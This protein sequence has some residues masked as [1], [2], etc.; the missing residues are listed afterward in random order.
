MKR[1]ILGLLSVLCFVLLSVAAAGAAVS[2]TVSPT[3]ITAD[4]TNGVTFKSVV[5]AA[6]GGLLISIHRDFHNA[7]TLDSDETAWF[8]AYALD[9]GGTKSTFMGLFTPDSNTT[10]AN[11]VWTK[12]SLGADGYIS[13]GKYIVRVE[14]S[15]GETATAPFT[16]TQANVTP[17]SYVHV[18]PRDPYAGYP[19]VQGAMV[20]YGTGE[21]DTF[22]IKSF[23]YSDG[24]NWTYLPITG[25]APLKGR[26]GCF[27]EGWISDSYETSYLVNGGP[28]NFGYYYTYLYNTGVYIEGHVTSAKDGTPVPGAAMTGIR[29]D[30]F[31][32]DRYITDF[33]GYYSIPAFDSE[34]YSVMCSNA[35]GYYSGRVPADGYNRS[36]VV[37]PVLGTPGVADFVAGPM[38][39]RLN[40]T[41]RDES[42]TNLVEGAVAYAFRNTTSTDP[43]KT[44]QRAAGFYS[45]SA[46]TL[47]PG[48]GTGD[49]KVGVCL[50]CHFHPVRVGG[51]DKEMVSP[52]EILVEGLAGGETRNVTLDAYYADGAVE[53]RVLTTG[54]VKA[55]Y[56]TKVIAW[57]DNALNG[58]D[59]TSVGRIV[60]S[61]DTDFDGYFRLPLL[62]GTW[63]VQAVST[64][65]KVMTSHYTVTI[66]TNGD[67]LI[68]A[69]AGEVGSVGT[70]VLRL[71]TDT[72]GIIEV[73]PNEDYADAMPM[74]AGDSVTGTL[75]QTAD[76]RQ[77]TFSFTAQKGDQIDVSADFSHLGT[78]C[79]RAHGV[80]LIDSNHSTIVS[81]YTG[82][83]VESHKAVSH[84]AQYTGT[85][86]IQVYDGSCWWWNSFTDKY[87]AGLTVTPPVSSTPVSAV[88]NLTEGQVISPESQPSN[89]LIV[90]GTAADTVDIE[91]VQ[92][93]LDGGSTWNAATDTS[94]GGTWAT[95]SYPWV[96]NQMDGPHS[97]LTRITDRFGMETPGPGVNVFIGDPAYSHGGFEP[98]WGYCWWCDW[99]NYVANSD[100]CNDG[101]RWVTLVDDAPYT[102]VIELGASGTGTCLGQSTMYQDPNLNA[103]KYDRVMLRSDFR[104]VSSNTADACGP[105]G[106]YA[107]FNMQVVYTDKYGIQ[108]W[109]AWQF[110][111]GSG[112]C[113][114]PA[115]QSNGTIIPVTVT[116][117]DWHHFEA[118]V[119]SAVPD[120][121][122]INRVYAY[123]Q[124][125][126][127]VSHFDN[128]ALIGYNDGPKC[129]I[130]T[131]G[132]YEVIQP[133]IA[134]YNVSGT[135]VSH[136]GIVSVELSVNVGEWFPANID[137]VS[138]HTFNWSHVKVKPQDG[139]YTI[140]ARATDINGTV[141]PVALTK[142]AVATNGISHS[143]LE[144]WYGWCWYCD[145]NNDTSGAC[146]DRSVASVHDSQSA[147]NSVQL[148]STGAGTC[149]GQS[150]MWQDRNFEANVY[151]Q[152][153]LQ[154]NVKAMAA[155]APDGCGTDGRSAPF[156]IRLD[157]TDTA[158]YA[159]ALIW[160][161][162][163]DAGTCGTPV[164][165][166]GETVTFV[167]V[168]QDEWYNFSADIYALAPDIA[169]V[170]RI[171]CY[172]Q[173]LDYTS[174]FDNVQ[175]LGL[176]GAPRSVITAPVKYQVI[177]SASASY[178][179]TGYAVSHAG[180]VGI[181][182]SMDGGTT[183]M[184]MNIDSVSD[185]RYYW[186][187]DWVLPTDGTYNFRTRAT[188][189]DGNVETP[190]PGT[191]FYVG[192]QLLSH[193]NFDPW[194]GWCTTCDWISDS[195]NPN[196]HNVYNTI[197]NDQPF[198]S[199]LELGATGSGGNL[200]YSRFYQGLTVNTNNF[201]AM[202]LR[203][204]VKSVS[205]DY[206][207]DDFGPMNISLYTRDVADVTSE[208]RW[209][210]SY[211]GGP[212]GN[213]PQAPDSIV[214]P[215][216]S[217]Q[218]S[219]L[220]FMSGDIKA[221]LPGISSIYQF[222]VF[223]YGYD[224]L[225]RTDNIQLIGE[226]FS[227][228]SRL[229]APAENAWLTGGILTVNG[230]VRAAPGTTLTGVEVTT[231]DGATWGNAT[232][233]STDGDMSTWSYDWLDPTEGAH[234]VRS[235][236]TGSNG[237]V[238]PTSDINTVS[239]NVDNLV[240]SSTIVFPADGASL[241]G[242][243]IRIEVD[244]TDTSVSAV[245]VSLDGGATWVAG[246]SWYWHDGNVLRWAYDWHPTVHQEYH[247]L[248]RATDNTGH[249]EVPGPGIFVTV[250][251][252]AFDRCDGA[253]VVPALPYG[254]SKGVNIAIDDT[255]D[256]EFNGTCGFDI[257]RT[258]W[259]K[260]TPTTFTGDIT[261]DT[262]T[263][264]YDTSL[265]VYTGDCGALTEVAC[266]DDTP[267]GYQSEIVLPVTAG[268]TYYIMVSSYNTTAGTLNF[269]IN[270]D[271]AHCT[272]GY[273]DADEPGIDCGGVNCLP[274]SLK[275]PVI[276]YDNLA[277]GDFVNG[278][279]YRITGTARDMAGTSGIQSVQ[280]SLNGGTD[281]TDVTW[282]WWEGPTLH[283]YYDWTPAAF[284]LYDISARVTD[285]AL[286]DTT[287]TAT[288]V[289]GGGSMLTVVKV[290]DGSGTVT[291]LP[292]G[293][294]CGG[295]CEYYFENDST[296]TLSHA[297]D[298]ATEF[299]GW[300][301][302]CTGTGDCGV[303]MDQART[304]NAS[305]KRVLVPTTQASFDT[306]QEFAIGKLDG[307]EFDELSGCVKR[308]N[309]TGTLPFLWIPNNNDTIS[310]IDVV[311]GNELG[312]Y[313]TVPSGTSGSPS[314][315][316]VDLGGNVW[317]ANRNAG[318]VVQVGLYENNQYMDRNGDGI[319]QTSHDTNANGVIDDA[320]VLPWG[321]DECVLY[322]VRLIPGQEATFVPGT[323]TVYDG[324]IGLRSLAIDIN[325]NLWVG[326]YGISKFYYVSGAN[327][328][329][330][331]SIDV[332]TTG[333]YGAV[334]D[335]YGSVWSSV[336]GNNTI[337]KI[338]PSTEPPTL[339]TMGISSPYG[340]A[341]DR[342][343]H[344]FV[345][346]YGSSLVKIN[347]QTNAVLGTVDDSGAR[348]L[349]VSPDN[350]VWIANSYYNVVDRYD[351][352]GNFI[353]S[354]PVGYDP[355]G[356]A[357][358]SLGKIWV[359]CNGTAVIYR[360]DP[361]TNTVE[362]EKSIAASGHYGYSDMTG[363]LSKTVT[364]KNGSWTVI[365]DGGVPGVPR[366][367][368]SWTATVPAGAALDVQARS[369]EDLVN[370]SDWEPAVNGELL[371][372]TPDG[373]YM[374][375]MV[376]FQSG[377]QNSESPELCVL[378]IA[379]APFP[380]AVRDTTAPAGWVL[381][382]GGDEQTT[383]TAVN[384]T[385]S[386]AD[387]S[388]KV[389]MMRFSN[390]NATWSD[391]APY[392]TSAPWTLSGV[393][394]KD[395]V[396][397]QFKD[398]PG[399]IV[400]VSDFIYFGAD[401]DGDGVWITTDNCPNNYNPGQ[402]DRDHDGLGDACDEVCNNN[403]VVLG[404]ITP[405]HATPG[406][407][408][409][410][411]TWTA[412][413]A[414]PDYCGTYLYTFALKG[415]GTGNV[416]AVRQSYGP[417][418]HWDWT[419]GTADIGT[420]YVKVSVK[421]GATGTVVTKTSTAFVVS[422]DPDADGVLGASDNCPYAANAGQSDADADGIG[423]ACDD[424]DADGVVDAVDNCWVVPNPDQAD[425][426]A[427]GKGSAC[428]NCAT[429]SNIDQAESD[430]DG[431]GDA[432][433][434]CPSVQNADQADSDSDG[435]G[436]ACDNCI[437]VANPDQSDSDGDGVGDACDNCPVTWNADQTDSDGDGIGNACDNCPNLANPDQADNDGDGVGNACDNCPATYN[438]DQMDQDADG[439]GD[440]CDNCPAAANVD[441]VDRDGDGLGDA[442][443]PACNNNAVTITSVTA[444]HASP[445]S[446]GVQ[447]VWTANMTV[448][449]K[450]GTYL[451][452]FALKGPGTGNVFVVKQS[453]GP[454]DHWNW[455]PTGS[456]SG[457]NYVK[458]SVKDGAAGTVFTKTSTAYVISNDPDADG[459]LGASDNCP[460]AANADQADNDADGIGD[461][462]D[463]DNDNDGVANESDNCPTTYNPGQENIDGD[464]QGDVCDEN[465]DND[466][467]NNAT[468]NCPSVYNWGQGDFDAD[469]IGDACDGDSDGDGI[470]N[471]SDPCQW[472]PVNDVDGDGSCA[473]ADNCPTTYNPGQEN[474]DGDGQGDVCDENMDNDDQNNA[475]DN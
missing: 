357:V 245:E 25:A 57:S 198:T 355:T 261:I 454:S 473:T 196:G 23:G 381:I 277:D 380:L 376:S 402:E 434:N 283:W 263:S 393:L 148:S 112:T 139:I 427:D 361:V 331:R 413:P 364:A 187:Y 289:H 40:I 4:N 87:V 17:S 164:A 68:D 129:Q 109:V 405:S 324:G 442:C 111:D 414:N 467:Q 128:Y 44:S 32:T 314:R 169:R 398:V 66:T 42:G 140:E 450:C 463:T 444:D 362:M 89:T 94:A 56:G 58:P 310:K 386:A 322:E 188:D 116:V 79:N 119:H 102:S 199:V 172:A 471:A 64:D 441:Q 5:P 316:T 141:S 189:V 62:G 211:P 303:T 99:G 219:W 264:D 369:S 438:A 152:L 290:G 93:S 396:Y 194:W 105:N 368:I 37:T 391:W 452:T 81:D 307:V 114:S 6:G 60:T 153:I 251:P 418:D 409:V 36:T 456:D 292:A 332:P 306:E 134:A 371:N 397:A 65:W 133:G 295:T 43:L 156:N 329:I 214:V 308:S 462:C 192:D 445:G 278:H 392:A 336:R 286:T 378:T 74:A 131:P 320:E 443:D 258:V 9:N 255:G 347:A 399:N 98:W 21:G 121:A 374:E 404:T 205:S 253:T 106:A 301:G 88:N 61:T 238:E 215:V 108:K 428:D 328:Q 288:G 18:L 46:G 124:G 334:I 213:P 179:V 333:H 257:N 132:M 339:T 142:C 1:H 126:D 103:A 150:R 55:Q 465:M 430:G 335:E 165:G 230:A 48:L 282:S 77:S 262:F 166:P 149:E 431:L 53:G 435:V 186:H 232:I 47:M 13:P 31:R 395:T 293:V 224:Y 315:T 440:A 212:G 411:T 345:A 170:T 352:D 384:L 356:V 439:V 259:Y 220:D 73:K 51:V 240:P 69:G 195:W 38:T 343:G 83:D 12:F 274:C 145:W 86:Y 39:A 401:E 52:A 84:T 50:N 388:G 273:R 326:G 432:C 287:V 173:G 117:G 125:Q 464:G 223:G 96:L 280:I 269:H 408:G 366:A 298:A 120:V 127:Y 201:D 8:R 180:I 265:T 71:P 122:T 107:P 420:N 91:M 100:G 367:I 407:V 342:L 475:T 20:Y 34:Q 104:I 403:P 296:V 390:D 218:G 182:F 417:S 235:R 204:D 26:V 147:N 387:N 281:W 33:T 229:D 225:G 359:I 382:N 372:Y 92:L 271:A 115:P 41:V 379:P 24:A 243:N 197:I 135:A 461:A 19:V 95:W 183:W 416:F 207:G 415:P 222:N 161:F 75:S 291:S 45:N 162:S 272:N 233:L 294:D 123:A 118:D 419:P 15:L 167:P 318:T 176:N 144:P 394:G 256:P 360:I 284:G 248:V 221:I 370:W 237:S 351:N 101:S 375:I 373:R 433:D 304:V 337:L 429:V 193:G 143:D 2:V 365:H 412:V 226:K 437:A 216:Q 82:T 323:N 49:W 184:P 202:F 451:Y 321:Q 168:N 72:T 234:S 178:N 113:A 177:P 346:G 299:V 227:P 317:V 275:P 239:V 377:S 236:A 16:V 11:A 137:S 80:W 350:N 311:T 353:T 90:T 400:T 267:D 312:R 159:K 14:N 7:G 276:A 231:D 244:T 423:D 70:M 285:G 344:V 474:I 455:T 327:G 466:D 246:W 191:I 325:N 63:T 28:G 210:F 297:E 309:T 151:D 422:N 76:E 35:P 158:G 247:I 228:R 469:G 340:I 319:I 470:D 10:T 458:V 449:D 208:L 330:M 453:Y 27:K 448:P 302:P 154:A 163:Y 254:E 457:T 426:D 268:T 468:D 185:Y 209:S 190:G 446:V 389:S 348:G 266:N 146:G 174:R 217:A 436:D 421:D 270:S 358:D 157:Y 206:T 22:R 252:Y 3:K 30:R 138:G 110:S 349:A 67:E 250:D 410:L 136:D 171:T 305:F 363:E 130:N 85:Y 447:T 241:T 260:Y 338:D 242:T 78:D 203:A 155:T 406:S 425:P 279:A 181:E 472:D 300:I 249:T 200:S 97:V 341:A 383:N 59:Q 175:L 313:R 160:T 385:L 424:F 54:G 460:Y 354:I 29:A 459:V